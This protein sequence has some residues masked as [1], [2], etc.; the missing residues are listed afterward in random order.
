MRKDRTESVELTNMCMVYDGR[1]NVLVQNRVSKGWP[2]LTFPGGHVEKGEAFADSVVREVYEETGLRIR[3][4]ALCGVKQWIEENRRYMVLCY[5]TNSFE[6]EI[7]SSKEGEIKWM[8]LAEMEQSGDKLASN[9]KSML[10][11]FT[12]DNLF[13]EYA[14]LE[15]G[16]WKRAFK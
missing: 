2:G 15:D 11:L 16:V 8:P 4:P 6:G 14:Y 1:G 5:K 13:E 3:K 9:M 10:K 12:E 7:H